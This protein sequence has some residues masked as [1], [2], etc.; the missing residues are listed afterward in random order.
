MMNNG[1]AAEDLAADH[2]YRYQ[3]FPVYVATLLVLRLTGLYK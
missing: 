3:T 1:I 2:Q